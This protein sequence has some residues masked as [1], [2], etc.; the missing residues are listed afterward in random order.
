VLQALFVFCW[1]LLYLHSFVIPV[2]GLYR[3]FGNDFMELYFKYKVYLL[4]I[5]AGFRFP[6]WSPAE[7]AGYPFYSNPFAQAFYPLNVL[8]VP[9]YKAVG[10]YTPY[11]HQVFTILGISIFAS[12]LFAWLRRIN[13]NPRAVIFATVVMSVSFKVTEIMRFPNAVH[14]AAWYPWIL[15]AMTR[16]LTNRSVPD[17]LTSGTLL[18]VFLICLCTGGYP[19][20]VYYSV[21]LFGPYLVLFFANPLRER[22]LGIRQVHWRRSI[23][24]M[25]LA[26]FVAGA[27]CYP[28]LLATKRLMDRTV[29]RGGGGYAYST[30]HLFNFEDTVGSLVYPPAAQAEGWYFFSVAALLVILL[31]LFLARSKSSSLSFASPSCKVFLLVWIGT[32]SYI[33]YGR[34]S[35]LFSALWSFFPGFSRLRVWGRMNIVLVPIIAWLLSLAYAFLEETLSGP[36]ANEWENRWEHYTPLLALS[37]AYATVLAA[38]LYFHGNDITDPYWPSYFYHLNS[39]KVLFLLYG[40]ASFVSLSLLLAVS[41]WKSFDSGRRRWLVLVVLALLAS[42]EMEPVGTRMWVAGNAVLQPSKKLAVEKLNAK[43]FL[44]PRTER[45]GTISLGS[46]F[47]VGVVDNWYFQ[48]YV[49][50]REKTEDEREARNILLGVSKAQK[51]FYSQSIEYATVREY[52]RDA[53]RFPKTGRL[54]FYNGDQLRWEINAPTEGYF[55]FIDNWDDGWIVFVDGKPSPMKLLFGTFKSVHIPAGIH[56]VRFVYRP[57]LF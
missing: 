14:T 36:A 16:I 52:L 38:Q 1:P 35:Y 46:S 17:L 23:A 51:I 32:I 21:F 53:L 5:L 27:V 55:S 44:R 26:A 31:Y 11:A 45:Y 2:D 30:S 10:Y 3:S 37:L 9:Y 25:V 19:Y 12:G 57:S 47:N 50:F 48:R 7:A 8:L 34:E 56:Q 18:C 22:L 29:D 49:S 15:Y 24:A 6:L 39:R 42:V 20:Y 4:D 41:R 33:T 28:Y 43:S 40:F 13:A 54:L